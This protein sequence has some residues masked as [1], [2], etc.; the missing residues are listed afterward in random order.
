MI[1][2]VCRRLSSVTRRICNV[3][4]QGAARGGPVLLRPV[5]STPFNS[6]NNNHHHTCNN[7]AWKLILIELNGGRVNG[8]IFGYLE[9]S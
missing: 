4:H 8:N 2:G 9:V 3:T 7:H 6:N 5:R 1:T